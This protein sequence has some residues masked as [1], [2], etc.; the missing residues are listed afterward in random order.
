MVTQKG[1][2]GNRGL[3]KYGDKI[4]VNVPYY[5]VFMLEHVNILHN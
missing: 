1:E 2:G 5:I 3:D 4:Y